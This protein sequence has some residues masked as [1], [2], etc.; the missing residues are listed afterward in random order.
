MSHD[1]RSY[2][3]LLENH[4]VLLLELNVINVEDIEK[5]IQELLP[6]I[7]YE[8]ARAWFLNA[9]RKYLINDPASN[10]R[11]TSISSNAPD[12][13]KKSHEAGQPLYRF[14]ATNDMMQKLGHLVD[15]LNSLYQ[16]SQEKIDPSSRNAQARQRMMTLAAKYLRGLNALDIRQLISPKQ[17]KVSHH[18]EDWFRQLNALTDD[19]EDADGVEAVVE[20]PNHYRWV[21]VKSEE[22]LKREGKLMGHCVGGYYPNVKAGKTVIYSLRDPKN[23][24]HC[25]IEVSNNHIQQIKGKGNAAPT[26]KYVSFVQDFL[27]RM[28]I[29]VGQGSYDL[30]RT[31]LIY[32]SANEKYGTMYELGE[33]LG[34]TASDLEF[35]KYQNVIHIFYKGRD[36]GTIA[37][38]QRYGDEI[39]AT[40]VVSNLHD[41]AATNETLKKKVY[42]EAIQF[43]NS[44]YPDRAVKIGRWGSENPYHYYS[45][46]NQLIHISDLPVVAELPHSSVIENEK[47][48]WFLDKATRSQVLAKISTKLTPVNTPSGSGTEAIKSDVIDFLNQHRDQVPDSPTRMLEAYGVIYN[49]GEYRPY[50]EAATQVREWSGGGIYHFENVWRM[51]DNGVIAMDW[52]SRS[53]ASRSGLAIGNPASVSRHAQDLV[54]VWKEFKY[55]PSGVHPEKL[56]ELKKL[57]IMAVKGEWTLPRKAKGV[58]EKG[59]SILKISAKNSNIVDA[60]G[61]KVGVLEYTGANSI[62][63][64]QIDNKA[65]G[66]FLVRYSAANPKVKF[67]EGA[68]RVSSSYRGGS[69]SPNSK[70]W[71]L[72]FFAHDGKFVRI[73]DVWPLKKIIDSGKFLWMRRAYVFTNNAPSENRYVLNDVDNTPKLMVEHNPNK[74]VTAITPVVNS[75]TADYNEENV[76]PYLDDLN[77]LI[78]TLGLTVPGPFAARAGLE[79]RDGRLAVPAASGKLRQFID[80]RIMYEDGH[81][82]VRSQYD[83]KEWKLVADIDRPYSWILDCEVVNGDIKHIKFSSAEFKKNKR[84][85][86][87]YMLDLM[88]VIDQL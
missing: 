54:E 69:S 11:V 5:K 31:G 26:V 55:T 27:N 41:D 37:I 59:Y 72:G 4:R 35:V 67:E 76:V 68:N 13:L 88:D 78:E 57:G 34:Q 82:W 40:I 6:R 20:Y 84:L 42:D 43:L 17:E 49:G 64:V 51:Y 71:Q 7:E 75:K 32:D 87:E 22:A 46:N 66:D 62:V 29:P 10:A 56:S 39:S 77:V 15:W 21:S 38:D 33:K 24:P 85:Y 16:V 81:A 61:T 48:Y 14:H 79:F 18:V 70:I 58:D 44:Q 45:V 63:G 23:A 25:T 28:K 3:D 8:P 74:V 9:V 50:L 73:Q 36:Y 52:N 80:G 19:V 30:E 60:D 65:A 83:K 47:E 1:I 2:I 53:P 12:W 86:R